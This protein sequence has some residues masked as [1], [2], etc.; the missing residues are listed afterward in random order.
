MTGGSG[1]QGAENYGTRDNQEFA[2]ASDGANKSGGGPSARSGSGATSDVFRVGVRI[3]PFW[4][5]EPE[6]WF[7]QVE[8]QFELSN[9][10]SDGTK[11]NFVAS[12]L[13]QE[14]ARTMKDILINPPRSGK[15]DTFKSELIKRISA[16]R[17][18]KTLQ[19]IQHEELGERK[20]TQFLRHLRDLAGPT[21]PDEF[22]RTIWASRLPPN[23]QTIVASQHNQNL[24]DVAELA[25]RVNDVTQS[26]THI[27]A[28]AGTPA[29]YNHASP[30][31]SALE[32]RVA[33]LTRQ[34][35]T[36]LRNQGTYSRSRS[37]SRG[38]FHRRGSR[39]KSR[40]RQRS[41]ERPDGHPHCWYHYQFGNNAKNCKAPCDFKPSLN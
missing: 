33:E 2:D 15:Y 22:I 11:F 13:D 34:V 21:I 37:H 31:G 8:S 25:D 20:P 24:G 6:V 39:S 40:S 10:T 14:Y 41:R 7:A 27:A 9:V 3:P 12:Q 1:E 17:E 16:T 18:K 28:V 38:R 29:Q 4:P 32:A 30:S 23:V 26:S 36:L 19:L 35:E 5:E